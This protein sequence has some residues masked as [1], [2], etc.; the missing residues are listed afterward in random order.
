M[1]VDN[2]T[3]SENSIK[4]VDSKKENKD[5]SRAT[6]P[7]KLSIPRRESQRNQN[8]LITKK[9]T[10][11]VDNIVETSKNIHISKVKTK[12][13][14]DIKKSCTLRSEKH[15]K[16]KQNITDI[17][18]KCKMC[19]YSGRKQGYLKLHMRKQKADTKNKN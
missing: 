8:K 4:T 1:K 12:S 6:I 10:N 17:I 9:V 19:S 15:R 18:F 7:A 2:D 13:L 16:R 3:E 11:M 14:N 5:I